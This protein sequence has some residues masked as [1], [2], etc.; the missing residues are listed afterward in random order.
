MLTLDDARDLLRRHA[1][2]LAPAVLDLE[3]AGGCRLARPVVADLPLPL[4]DVSA[5]DGYAVRA[6]DL[7]GGAPL[8]VAAE[9]PA[10][11]APAPLAPG[12]AAR[13]FTG[14]P[15]PAGADTVVP[16]EDAALDAAARTV[17]LD[18]HERGSHVRHQGELFAAGA[19]LMGAGELLTAPRVA[20]AA[21][22]GAARVGIVP[23]P[24]VAVV[25][26]GSELVDADATP[27]AGQLRDSNGPLLAGLVRAFRLVL[28]GRVRV[29]DAEGDLVAAIEAAA[30]HAEI[31]ITSGG[32]SVGDF[33]L[34][35]RALAAIGAETLFH[36]VKMKPGKPI[37][38]AR[39]GATWF[40]GLPGNPLAALVAWRLFAAP[41][42][43]ALAGN[44]G[45]FDEAPL[46]LPAAEAAE[47]DGKRLL[48]R[49]AEFARGRDGGLAVR[50]VPW[51]GSH[52]IVA[53]AAAGALVRLE[54]GER[55]APG[56]LIACV[57]LLWLAP[58]PV[59]S[60]T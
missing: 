3:T 38:A 60:T 18:T 30:R 22:A 16:Q 14:A 10:G 54:P 29:A 4:S 46:R 58:A 52:D 31:V 13:I 36:G 25:L 5:M 47:N 55:V 20:L 12:S 7:A 15:L 39:R 24:R 50:V 28:A 21:A 26:S 1:A 32:V 37:L 57:P 44:A 35:P 8:P 23:R 2:P 43:E 19:T 42:A 49:P 59:S 51:K 56:G 34:V 33:D 11:A 48:V 45:A 6:I 27:R 41:L 53:G 17:R 40:L 9:I